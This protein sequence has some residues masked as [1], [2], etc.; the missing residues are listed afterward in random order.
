MYDFDTEYDRRG[1]NSLKW[2]VK[3]NELAMWVADMDFM[4]APEIIEAV[5]KRASQGIWGY[6]NVSDE[7]YKA[8]QSWWLKRHHFVIEKEWLIFCTGVIPAISTAVNRIT[9]PGDN[10]LVQTPAYN[11]FYNSIE[12]HGRHVLEN[13]LIYREGK[14]S[15]DFDDLEEK[16]AHPLTTMMIL[17]NPHN[18]SGKIWSSEDLLMVGEL[19]AK[20]NV[21][22]LS[23]EIHCD[24]TAPDREYT[25]FAKAGRVCQDNSITCVAAS[26]AFNMAGIQSAAVIIPN[27]ALRN[28]MN[29]GLNSYEVA[30][31]NVFAC[32][33]TVAAFTK[34]EK[35]LDELCA[36]VFDNRKIA[37]EYIEENI[38]DI[39]LINGKATY[40]LWIDVSKIT[41]DSRELCKSIRANTGLYVSDGCQYR[42]DGNHFIR[43]NAACP[44]SRLMEGLN[45]LK[46]G[47]EMY[48]NN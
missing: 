13:R 28:K 7:W 34:G 27:E 46:K 9:N 14:Y 39:S 22:V 24:I 23:D 43:I 40:L 47:I 31:P 38:K 48:K 18:P 16:L 12:N 21:V 11:T 36:Y 2:D 25:P 33:A 42:G 17:C 3:D 20:H 10:V 8:Y 29:R 1:T 5:Q 4:T 44:K 35:W 26:K 30:E 37:K 32:E 41:D 15:M 6:T 19:C 45:R